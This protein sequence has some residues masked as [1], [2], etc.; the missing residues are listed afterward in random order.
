MDTFWKSRSQICHEI[1]SV[2]PVPVL[3]WRF[4]V[5]DV[6]RI[7]TCVQDNKPMLAWMYIT[8]FG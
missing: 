1:P 4:H 7:P 3:N 5:K 2:S 6:M 8:I